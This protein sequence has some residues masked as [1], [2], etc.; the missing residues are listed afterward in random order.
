[1]VLPPIQTSPPLH[2]NGLG[3]Y[4]LWKQ[5]YDTSNSQIYIQHKAPWMNDDVGNYEHFS[6]HFKANA[7]GR[8]NKTLIV[9]F[10]GTF[11]DF[12]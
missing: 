7:S 11:H 10:T 2:N 4:K 9:N 5:F 8:E 3:H 1:M 12:D 6:S